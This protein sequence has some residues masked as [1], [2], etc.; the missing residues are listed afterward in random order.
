MRSDQLGEKRASELLDV[1]AAA[2]ALPES[3]YPKLDQRNTQQGK[4]GPAC[5]LLK[6][7]LKLRCE[8]HRVAQKLVASSDDIEAIARD[9]EADVPALHGWRRELYGADALALKK[10]RLAITADGG[11]LRVIEIDH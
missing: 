3:E 1:V 2:L 11:A 9:D 5:D 7:L 6:V 8:Q 4:I 10:G